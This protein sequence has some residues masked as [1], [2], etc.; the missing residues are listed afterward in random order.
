M[1]AVLLS[2]AT[3]QVGAGK[4]KRRPPILSVSPSPRRH[5]GAVRGS[6]CVIFATPGVS[7]LAATVQD[8]FSVSMSPI[9]YSVW[10]CLQ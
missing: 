1:P 5:F 8:E 2:A 9:Y 10:G 4:F 6:I 3:C 7:F